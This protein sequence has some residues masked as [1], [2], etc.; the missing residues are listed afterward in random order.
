MTL[1]TTPGVV[2]TSPAASTPTY[3]YPSAHAKA[4]KKEIDLL[5]LEDDDEKTHPNMATAVTLTPLPASAQLSGLQLNS[6]LAHY[7]LPPQ[8]H[9]QTH[10]S[11]NPQSQS[12]YPYQSQFSQPP[13][14]SP[15]LS[16]RNSYASP[17]TTTTAT[18]SSS[19]A[20]LSAFGSAPS[21]HT[22]TAPPQQSQPGFSF[23]T[24]TP[25]TTTAKPSATAN[26]FDRFVQT[27]L[28]SNIPK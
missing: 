2:R 25:T 5:S 6:P 18:T 24:P 9:T 21:S 26:D 11:I 22:A 15:S 17:T 10:P 19:S 20:I 3:A 7:S 12:Q 28:S 23:I 27:Q 4:P 16:G 13:Q 1:A 8:P 14:P